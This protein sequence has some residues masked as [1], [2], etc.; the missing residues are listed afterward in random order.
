VIRV[1]PTVLQW[2]H[3]SVA[4]VKVK[5]TGAVAGAQVLQ[6]Y[7]SAPHSS[8]PRPLKELHGFE[9]VFLQPGEETEVYISVDRYATSFWDEIESMWKS[10]KGSYEV[11]VGSS[12]QEIL[13][14]GELIVPETRHWLGL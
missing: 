4:I 12:S 7:I 1:V 13:G 8:T 9:K 14:K 3:L 10:E 2:D 5:N 11:L 6:L